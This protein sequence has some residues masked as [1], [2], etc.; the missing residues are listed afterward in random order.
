METNTK[1]ILTILNIVS[2]VIFIGLL[3]NTGGV[4]FSYVMSLFKPESA[5]SLYDGLNLSELERS[6]FW[7]YTCVISFIVALSGLKA[8]LFYLVIQLF[9][10]INLA[11]PFRPEIAAL[12]VTISHNALGI[13]ILALIA[14][15]YSN[16]LVKHGFTAADTLQRHWQGSAEFLLL[17]GII[18]IIGQVFKRGVELQSEHELTI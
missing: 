2:W 16:W 14:N 1:Q 3:I 17:A 5:K 7:Y 4:A 11:H 15:G 13:A 6:G 9:S 18:Y 8:Y 12:I 10:K